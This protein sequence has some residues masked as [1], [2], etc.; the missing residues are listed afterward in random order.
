[1]KNSKS[2]IK[3]LKKNIKSLD[4]NESSEEEKPSGG[5]PFL[6]DGN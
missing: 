1:M 6:R 5:C 4:D 3:K 2:K